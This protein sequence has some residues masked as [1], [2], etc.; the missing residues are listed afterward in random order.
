MDVQVIHGLAAVF[1][2]I[3]DHAI[4]LGEPLD[5]RQMHSD[6]QQ[7]TEQCRLL[8]LFARSIERG[9]VLARRDQDMHG[10]LRMNVVEG[11]AAVVLVD[12]GRRDASFNDFAEEAVCHRISVQECQ[13]RII[14]RAGCG[15]FVP[16]LKKI[17]T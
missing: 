9:P 8:V 13:V 4:A 3:D 5:A 16:L 15:E 12:P 1:A 6:L 11:V 7:M 17:L 2:D 10:R 14:L